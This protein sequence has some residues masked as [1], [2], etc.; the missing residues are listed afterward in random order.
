MLKQL[1]IAFRSLIF[2]VLFL[3]FSVFAQSSFLDTERFHNPPKMIDGWRAELGQI[4][5]AVK[6]NGIN[7]RELLNLRERISALRNDAVGF[8]EDLEPPLNNLQNQLNRLVKA[9]KDVAS[10]LDAQSEKEE[11]SSAI[12]GDTSDKKGSFQEKSASSS[13]DLQNDITVLE[14]DISKLNAWLGRTEV[15]VLRSNELIDEISELRRAKFTGEL[16]GRTKSLL[17]PF[18]WYNSFEE[19]FILSRGFIELLTSG[20]NRVLSEVPILFFGVLFASTFI[21][22]LVWH[23]LKRQPMDDEGE[24]D[25]D[26]LN[27]KLQHQRCVNAFRQI[28]RNVVIFSLVPFML[29]LVIDDAGV[30]SNRLS[31]LLWT[32][33]QAIFYYALARGLSRSILAPSY[34]AHRLVDLTDSQAAYIHRT[35]IS[36]LTIVLIGFTAVDFAKT[37]V[38]SADFIA[39]VYSIT[40]FV[41]AFM[42][43]C[44]Y[45]LLP[46]HNE[47]KL[48][49]IPNNLIIRILLILIFLGLVVALFAPLLGYADLAAFATKQVILA[50]IISSF[51]YLLFTFSDSFFN[52]QDDMSSSITSNQQERNLR[53]TQIM[54]LA[55]GAG[56][57]IATL[58]G[59]SFLAAS[60]GLDTTGIWGSLFALFEEVRIGGLVISPSTILTALLVF[61][62]GLLIVRSLQRWLSTRFLPTTKLDIGLR[63][64]IATGF[65]YLGFILS[66]MIAFSQAGLDLGNLAIVAGALSLGIGFGLQSIVSNFVSGIILLAE[67]PI[68]V[69]DWIAVG[70]EEGMVKKISVRS[71]EIETFDRASVIVPNADFIS[72]AVKNMMHGNKTGRFIVPVGVG[73]DNDP[74]EIR[75][76]LLDIVKHHPLVLTYPQPHVIF[77][78]FG[79]SSLDFEL[80]GFLADVGNSL[81]VRSDLRFSI[82]K[83]LKE[84][85]IEIPFP[86]RDLNIKGLEQIVEKIKTSREDG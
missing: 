61:A 84:E 78:D 71:T 40:S 63:N 17:S 5:K 83:R 24:T 57:I 33:L 53:Q 29:L 47:N 20:A 76:I 65:G 1:V 73:Y 10:S 69:G 64:S 26:A 54:M 39:F 52:L 79:A 7:D 67:R 23:Y 35:V 82:F 43:F 2:L 60:W 86:Q 66:A 32:I 6:R 36:C 8:S 55:V 45:F 21:L 34:K 11:N 85:G 75:E 25:R 77:A 14:S 81:A 16:L 51:L 19:F 58:I 49:Q 27:N 80:R 56:K 70:G 46:G 12:T 42:A 41:F 62:L 3:P 13:S 31:E 59:V 72:G 18:L 4:S 30:L 9:D 22:A 37:L 44:S 50:G 38:A 15:I 28:A 48:Y 68:K 74:E